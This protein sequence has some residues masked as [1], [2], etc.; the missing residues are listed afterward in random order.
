MEDTKMANGN[1]WIRAACVCAALSL[2]GCNCFEDLF[3]IDDDDPVFVANSPA[4]SASPAA[5]PPPAPS[6]LVIA[7]PRFN[8]NTGRVYIFRGGPGLV[9]T[10]AA[11]TADAIIDGEAAGDYFGDG[12]ALADV[13][14]DRAVDLLVTAPSHEEAGALNRGRAYVF[15]GATGLSG[16]LGAAAAS[17][18]RIDGENNTDNLGRADGVVGGR[19]AVGAADVTGDGTADLLAAAVEHEEAGATSRGRVYVLTGG[20]G[21]SGTLGAAAAS[22][23]RVDGEN[24]FDR[25]STL[26]Q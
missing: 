11:G 26:A 23:L 25:L 17:S 21:L 6:L 10:L 13:A 3:G 19:L 4:P 1:G 8:G 24:D 12:L 22:S 18:A 5:T 2:A 9:G 20:A 16:I 7:A 14:G 15:A